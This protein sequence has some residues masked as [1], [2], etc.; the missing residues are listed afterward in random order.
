LAVV[1]YL[2][3]LHAACFWLYLTR[4]P[5][6]EYLR[7]TRS[8]HRSAD[9]L[10]PRGSALFFGDSLTQGLA[11]NA[12]TPNAVN[13]GIGNQTAAE[14]AEALPAYTSLARAGVVFVSIGTVDVHR[15]RTPD[16]TAVARALP[17]VPL[18]WS[19]LMIG[20]DSVNTAIRAA[21]KAKPRCIF[22]DT[23]SARHFLADQVHLSTDGYRAWIE[24]L[25]KAHAAQPLSSASGASR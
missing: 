3:A 4:D 20:P 11:V 1:V 23:A 9:A 12:V 5:V 13:F 19:G 2:I 22:V 18:V 21:C 7:E 8:H 10:I 16:I 15:G 24:L 6:R 17:D 25:R 14:L